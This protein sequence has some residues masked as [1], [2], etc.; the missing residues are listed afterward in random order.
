MSSDEAIFVNSQPHEE[1]SVSRKL[2]DISQRFASTGNDSISH[3][4]LKS[5]DTKPE[6][7][8]PLGRDQIL[9][10]PPNG[11]DNDQAGSIPKENHASIKLGDKQ[12]NRFL[13]QVVESRR[14]ATM[15]RLLLDTVELIG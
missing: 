11:K 12:I 2:D 4:L 13:G 1:S 14:A 6:M 7:N 10:S 3:G 5:G 15:K 9:S 8:S